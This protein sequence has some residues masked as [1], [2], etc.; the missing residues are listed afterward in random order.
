MFSKESSQ[1]EDDAIGKRQLPHAG[2]HKSTLKIR[3]SHMESWR[4]SAFQSQQLKVTIAVKAA[5]KAG[6]GVVKGKDLRRR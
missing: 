6:A 4:P 3:P 1:S 2:S 5:L